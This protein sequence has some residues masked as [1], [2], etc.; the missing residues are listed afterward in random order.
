[1]VLQPLLVQRA[2]PLPAQAAPRT[3][4][5]RWMACRTPPAAPCTKQPHADSRQRLDRPPL[6]CCGS[7]EQPPEMSAFQVLRVREFVPPLPRWLRLPQSGTKQGQRV[8]AGAT[9]Q[10][11]AGAGPQTPRHRRTAPAA[12]SQRY[13]AYSRRRNTPAAES[14]TTRHKSLPVKDHGSTGGTGRQ[15]PG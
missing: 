3:P 7:S 13:S 4:F 1:M 2:A 10:A 15:F 5:D 12:G 14:C 9:P 8:R 6:C 11:A